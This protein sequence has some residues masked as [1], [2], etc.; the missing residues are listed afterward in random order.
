MKKIFA[1]VVVAFFTMTMIVPAQAED[2]KINNL[3][4]KFGETA[5]GNGTDISVF[6]GNTKY[7]FEVT[8]NHQRAY[9]VGFWKI[10]KLNLSIG[11]C[12]G[13]FKNQV[14]TGPYVVFTPVKPLALFYWSGWGFGKPDNPSWDVNDFFAS[15]GGSLTFGNL[16][17][18]YVHLNF[19]GTNSSLPGVSFGIN[20]NPKTRVS[21]G[22]DVQFP[23]GQKGKPMYSVGVSQSF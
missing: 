14:Q 7:A 21:F 13:V 11:W 18:G 22:V 5:F 8:G 6:G 12:A 15:W 3:S 19:M 1:I 23:E 2:I 17:L 9:A 16:R 4:V 20:L 10:P